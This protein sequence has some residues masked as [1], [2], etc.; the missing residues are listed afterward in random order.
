MFF[1]N[2]SKKDTKLYDVLDVSPNAEDK[3]IK[4]SYR[5]LAL[6][7]HPDRNP[8]NKIESE[9]KF[10]EISAAYD[11]LSDKEKRNNYDK[12]GLDA[13]KNM[14]GPNINPFDIFSSMF[15]D[16]SKSQNSNG[17]NIF[18]GMSGMGG[19]FGNMFGRSGQSEQSVRVKNRL[20]KVSI[21]LDDI[22]NEKLF[23]VN[24]K[25]KCI[26]TGCNG[27]GGLYKS[28]VVFCNSCE[29][30]GN[31]TKIVQIGPGMISQSTSQCYKCNGMGKSIKP[32]ELCN[33]CNGTKYIN[34]D[35]HIKIELNKNIHTGSKIVVN[36]GGDEIIG[37]NMVGNLILEI[38]VEDHPI[39]S[40]ENNN[41]IMKQTILL[42]EA[43][44]NVEFVLKHMDNREILISLT[45]VIYP[46]MKQKI[47]G[48]GMDSNSDLII[49]FDIEFPNKLS[50]QRKTY[51]KKLLPI[52]NTII[53]KE[54]TIESIVVDYNDSTNL[55]TD[56]DYSESKDSG[57]NVVNCAQ[58]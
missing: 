18:E 4:K 27:S 51:L 1:N 47:I 28:S 30:K 16:E 15:G 23:N 14:G 31:I 10:K 5:K 34:K 35:T 40:R 3:D 45:K 13:V 42:S 33:I 11:I 48:E 24:L 17:P 41:L 7:Y 57:E 12:F 21:K 56:D 44:C 22:Y 58:Q 29:G 46:G 38:I 9:N 43:L 49:E 20:E 55:E 52:N 6:K 8:D 54:N 39:F 37:T 53:N 32:N 25:K 50:D 36:N 2:S 19:M 26:C